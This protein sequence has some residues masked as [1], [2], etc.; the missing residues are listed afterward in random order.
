[1]MISQL[2]ESQLEDLKN[3]FN[4]LCSQIGTKKRRGEPI[5]DLLARSQALSRQIRRL[6]EATR[7]SAAEPN[8]SAP[9]TCEVLGAVK[10]VH[11]LRDEWR[12]LLNASSVSSA[13]MNWGWVSAWYETYQAD[14]EICCFTV[15]SSTGHLIGLAPFFSPRRG[16]QWLVRNQLGLVGTWGHAW[17]FYGDII[18]QSGMERDVA[19]SILDHLVSQPDLYHSIKL[20]RILP[21]SPALREFMAQAA[22]RRWR[23][24]LKAGGHSVADKLPAQ[25]EDSLTAIACSTIRHKIRRGRARL[26]QEYPSTYTIC[27]CDGPELEQHLDRLCTFSI[28]RHDANNN[29]SIF[30]QSK[31][32]SFFKSACRNLAD[33]G[34]LRMQC[35]IVNDQIAAISVNIAAKA[36]LYTWQL[37]FDPNLLQFGIGHQLLLVSVE[38][39]MAEG[40]NEID[41]GRYYP[42]KAGYFSGRRFTL[43]ATLFP[44][45]A[46]GTWPVARELLDR[47]AREAVKGVVGQH[48]RNLVKRLRQR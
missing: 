19:A 35:I 28:Q 43:N 41:L 29:P 15:R 2:A 20:I 10:Q 18:C 45:T 42:Y 33:S 26:L 1:M 16:D 46:A 27:I 38:Q 14:G 4:V 9:F 5:N 48:G 31:V 34:N 12:Q 21:E 3:D 8:G 47:T 6:Q 25:G 23:I 11:D 17:S 37:G 30:T 40:L 44:E 24:Y 22:Q 13:F 32:C 7:P 39:G 36:C